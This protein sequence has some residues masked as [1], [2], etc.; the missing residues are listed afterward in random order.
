MN[1]FIWS[2]HVLEHIEDDKKA[3]NELYRVLSPKGMAIVGVPIYN[4]RTYENK[5]IIT[6]EERLI[7]FKP[8][9]HV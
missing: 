6:P 1:S 4:G 9:D 7:H 8:K 2:F 5:G 3:M